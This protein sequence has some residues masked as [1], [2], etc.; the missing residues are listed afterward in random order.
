MNKSQRI[1]INM[2]GMSEGGSFSKKSKQSLGWEFPMVG[3]HPGVPSPSDRGG[4]EEE[5]PLPG[6]LDPTHRT[7]VGR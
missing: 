4:V 5:V 2:R 7:V 3:E 1:D 6:M